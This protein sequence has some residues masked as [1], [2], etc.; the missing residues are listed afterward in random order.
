M[1]SGFKLGWHVR[2]G[3][4]RANRGENMRTLA[5]ELEAKGGGKQGFWTGRE[6]TEGERDVVDSFVFSP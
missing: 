3:Y 6:R 5:P 1:V 4:E 2:G